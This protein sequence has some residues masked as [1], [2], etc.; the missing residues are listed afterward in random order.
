[1]QSRNSEESS[2]SRSGNI[3]S[4]PNK[5]E[6]PRQQLASE[7]PLVRS[8]S[9]RPAAS[10]SYQQQAEAEP[11]LSSPSSLLARLNG[12]SSTRPN[13]QDMVSNRSSPKF[14]KRSQYYGPS[15]QDDVSSGSSIGG[16]RNRAQRRFR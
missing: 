6:A 2:N 11:S 3:Y 14:V 10:D 15:S 5:A 1:M 8:F 7:Q 13:P 4:R 12:L 16:P 9:T